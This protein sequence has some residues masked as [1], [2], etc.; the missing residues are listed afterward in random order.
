MNTRF[1]QLVLLFLV[2]AGLYMLFT[3]KQLNTSVSEL[4]RLQANNTHTRIVT[5]TQKDQF[6]DVLLLNPPLTV[7]EQLQWWQDNQS[8]LKDIYNIPQ[9][10]QNFYIG[11]TNIEEGF[12]S[13]NDKTWRY[14]QD[15]D[16]VFCIQSLPSP[17]NCLEKEH[18]LF[19]VSNFGANENEIFINNNGYFYQDAAGNIRR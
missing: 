9:D 7:E 16:S 12:R 17:L 10:P 15:P 19:R 13:L 4:L 3:V 8:L 1:L 2:G 11:F 18:A 6:Y 5:I 14:Y